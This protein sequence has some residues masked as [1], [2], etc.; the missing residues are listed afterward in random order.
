MNYC[1]RLQILGPK[2]IYYDQVVKNYTMNK[3]IVPIGVD[4]P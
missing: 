2:L 1:H 3:N 4:H